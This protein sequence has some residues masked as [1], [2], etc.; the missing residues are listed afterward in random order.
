MNDIMKKLQEPFPPEDVE[1]RVDRGQKTTNG[2]FVFV[3]VYITNRAIQARLDDVFGPFGWKNEF[4]EWK[5]QSQICGI[6]VWDSE[7]GEWVTKWDGADD[8]NMDAVKGGLSGAMKRAA[9]QWGIGRY[10]YNLEQNRVPLKQN[11][12]NWASVKVSKKGQPDEYIKGYW[13]A[14]KLPTW[15]LPEDCAPSKGNTTPQ[16][17]KGVQGQISGLPIETDQGNGSEF[18]RVV[19]EMVYG[20][21]C[22]NCRATV[23]QKVSDHCKTHGFDGTYCM[24]CQ[25]KFRKTS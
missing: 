13:D 8:S 14:P 20:L 17:D 18:A 1:W 22:A 23:S 12:E 19:D 2:N 7:K 21:Q 25:P 24:K 6:S 5:G 16:P 3:L 10:L 9:V 15:A 11:G 4:R